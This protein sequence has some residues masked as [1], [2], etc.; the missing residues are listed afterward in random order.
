[1]SKEAVKFWVIWLPAFVHKNEFKSVENPICDFVN[2]PIQK[3]GSEYNANIPI[4]ICFVNQNHEPIKQG[5]DIV[6]CNIKLNYTEDDSQEEKEISLEYLDHSS[7]G[8]FL[9]KCCSDSI[10]TIENINRHAT[11][12]H[13]KRICHLHL[14]HSNDTTKDD[15]NDFYFKIFATNDKPNI[16]EINGEA[17]RYYLS[18]F[19]DRYNRHVNVFEEFIGIENSQNVNPE[20]SKNALLS[21]MEEVTDETVALRL[22]F[23]NKDDIVKDGA[24][25]TII[26]IDGV[27]YD[28]DKLLKAY[29]NL[30]NAAKETIKKIAEDLNSL[31]YRPV[32]EDPV[33]MVSEKFSIEKLYEESVF[34]VGETLYINILRNSKYLKPGLENDKDSDEVRKHLLNLKNLTKT[35]Y[36]I[37]D[38]YKYRYEEKID[39]K[40]RKRT[41]KLAWAGFIISILTFTGGL[42][43]AVNSSRE[44]KKLLQQ[45]TEILQQLHNTPSVAPQET[46]NVEKVN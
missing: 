24:T 37:R 40:A 28:N 39:K 31:I 18:L 38:Y 26:D 6:G 3:D 2:D 36:F 44:T 20:I 15:Y 42:L 7:N 45:N 33:P 12:Y 14:F 16:N 23:I 13:L 17:I 35:L 29:T 8:L 41:G 30:E 9:Y 11:A 4:K 46:S 25:T 5:D 22:H 19:C 34:A 43:Y 1:M 10:Q 21:L 27:E 32:S